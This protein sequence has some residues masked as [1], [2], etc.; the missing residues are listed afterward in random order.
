APDSRT[1]RTLEGAA[2]DLHS[3]LSALFED[4][5]DVEAATR[6][7]RP[8]SLKVGLGS[9]KNSALLLRGH[10]L[11]RDAETGA[12][13]AFHLDEAARLPV[14]RDEIDLP[15]ARHEVAL[16]NPVA[17]L[18]QVL[19]GKAL[20]LLTDAAL[21]LVSGDATQSSDSEQKAGEQDPR[22][23]GRVEG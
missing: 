22:R 3:R 23:H 20:P 17:G 10:R 6:S 16:Q 15:D 19:L 21:A 2:Q 12:M 13:T 11:G 7:L 14:P 4:R 9:P 8:L 5:H 1:S 18:F